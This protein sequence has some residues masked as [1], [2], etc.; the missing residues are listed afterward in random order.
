M[1]NTKKRKNTE[2]K[3]TMHIRKHYGVSLFF[4]CVILFVGC[5]GKE[6]ELFDSEAMEVIEEETRMEEES[7]EQT[8]EQQNESCYVYVCGAVKYPGVYELKMGSR[9]FLAL[10]AAGGLREDAAQESINQAE[11]VVDGQMLYIPTKEEVL[12]QAE[13]SGF[14][15]EQESDDGRIDLNRADAESL[16]TLPGI[17]SSKAESIISYREECGGFSSVEEIMKIPGIKEGVYSK[18]KDKIKVE[19]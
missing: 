13:K 5:G 10:Q 8:K 14:E 17:G 3:K 2:H 4:M 9:V 12:A 1:K 18:I 16:M 6:D 11:V 19:N 7:L 15:G